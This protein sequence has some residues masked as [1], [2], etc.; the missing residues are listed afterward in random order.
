MRIERNHRGIVKRA[1]ILA[2]YP[3]SL[4]NFR[5]AFIRRLIELEIEVH[6]AAP[7]LSQ[8]IDVKKHLC[9]MG[10]TCHD[11]YIKRTGLNPLN[12]VVGLIRLMSLFRKVQPNLVLAYTIK[13]VIWGLKAASLVGVEQRV[14]LITGLGY[15]FTG[16][17]TGLRGFVQKIAKSLYKSSLKKAS[18]V[19]F[20]N[21]DDL[22]EFASTGLL[23]QHIRTEVVNG[24]GVDTSNYEHAAFPSNATIN[25]LLI[26]RLLGDK[27]IR[28]Y[29]S[30]ARK[31]CAKHPHAQFHLVGGL[32][33]NPNAISEE[34]V[35]AWVQEGVLQ[36]HGA[37]DDVRPFIA[38]SHVYVLP[39]YREGTPRSVLEAMSMGRAVITT[40]APG[41]RETVVDG[42]N[43]FLVDVKSVDQLVTAM[44][45]FILQPELIESMGQR[46]R[47]I[48]CEKYDVHKVNKAMLKAMGII[49]E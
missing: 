35:N 47:E 28:E 31:I 15:A 7:N 42:D 40:D 21:P 14:A 22:E 2:S 16:K 5:A 20:Q 45:R 46:S 39:S 41:C 49:K 38:N 19:F 12:D 29:V 13:P 30:A 33:T 37:V 25:Y 1:L 27:G 34:E 10:A 6:V 43:G 4:V 44:E 11:A 48:A 32:D 18:L 17:A 8:S 24:S 23:P 3:D 26:A 9:E 36:W